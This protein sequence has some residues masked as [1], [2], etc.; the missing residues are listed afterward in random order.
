MAIQ[1]KLPHRKGLLVPSRKQRDWEKEKTGDAI[2]FPERRL[3][4]SAGDIVSSGNSSLIYTCPVDKRAKISYASLSTKTGEGYI[5]LQIKTG[6]T[7]LLHTYIA[8]T[9]TY[10]AAYSDGIDLEPGDTVT[11]VCG[12]AA[13][14][15]AVGT[16]QTIEDDV[17]PGY[18]R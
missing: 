9:L 15:S 14:N 8:N 16:V 3:S 11:V 7:F 4:T 2:L 12:V 5:Q 13:G 18:L 10:N 1:K 6:P 17:S